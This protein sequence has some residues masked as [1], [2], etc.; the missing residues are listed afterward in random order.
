MKKMN[1]K[2]RYDW[3]WNINLSN[4]SQWPRRRTEEVDGNYSDDVFYYPWYRRNWAAETPAIIPSCTPFEPSCSSEFNFQEEGRGKVET[5]SDTSPSE[6]NM[7]VSNSDS[8][9]SSDMSDNGS[10]NLNDEENNNC[11]T[12]IDAT[13][14]SKSAEQHNRARPNAGSKASGLPTLCN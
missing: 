3:D 10:M 14:P 13:V 4:M 11:S 7:Q 2:P 12:S 1:R 6:E 5:C 9:H 8:T